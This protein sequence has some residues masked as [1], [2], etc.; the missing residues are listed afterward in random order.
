[1]HH[2]NKF[3]QMSQDFGLFSQIRNNWDAEIPV[4]EINMYLGPLASGAAVLADGKT[5]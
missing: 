5:H 3:K 1:M 2:R 4:H